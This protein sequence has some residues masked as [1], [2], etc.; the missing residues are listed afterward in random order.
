MKWIVSFAAAGLLLAATLA[1][2]A[3]VDVRWNV[4]VPMRDGVHLD[5]TVY[6]P[7][8]QKTPAPCIFTLT[9]YMADT[10]HERGMYFAAQGLPFLTIDD[11]GR[12]N[13]EGAFHHYRPDAR[14]GYDIVEWLAAQPYCNGKVG[15]WGGSYSGY[16]QWAVAKEAPPHLATIV[17]AAAVY[18]GL[19]FPFRGSIYYPFAMQWITMTSGRTA[20]T[21]VFGDRAFWTE[22]N[23]EWF[24]GGLPFSA[25]DAVV[26]NP[27]PVFQE[28][29]RH[30]HPDAYWDA[31]T[32]TTAQYGRIRHPVLTITG[33]YDA[34]QQG[35]LAYYRQHVSHA[36][37]EARDRH[38]LVIGPWDHQGTRTPSAEFGGL[39]LS[40][41]SLVDLPKLHVDWYRWT[42]Q[43]GPKPEF[44]RALVAYYVIGAERWRYA[45]SLQ[46]ITATRR[47]YFLQSDGSA[48]DVFASGTMSASGSARGQPDRY[49][50]DPRDI[51]SDRDS[52]PVWDYLLDQRT[53]YQS[54]GKQLVYHTAPFDADTELSGFFKLDAWLSID[55]PDT[56][57]GVSVYEIAQDGSSM[58]LT[59]DQIRA[60]YRENER[61]PK[62]VRTTEPLLYTFDRFTFISRQIR[63]GSRLRLV[64]A[65][66][67]SMYSEKNYNSGKSVSSESVQDAR[68]VRVTLYHDEAHPSSLYVPI[69]Q[70]QSADEHAVSKR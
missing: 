53:I 41:A 19:D 62:L 20:R 60:R 24:E 21:S 28:W 46:A 40:E 1:V 36:T 37:P 9:P 6:A 25:L 2:S 47:P 13:S 29:L 45:S 54:A 16:N 18:P 58:L 56:D 11:R 26:G 66:I 23:R 48:S 69:A 12:G 5:A 63:K 17:P 22:K 64:I 15:M 55:Q 50:Y 30:P 61:A 27:S 70:A 68:T 34:D 33:S 67:N 44:L 51:G 35:A 49:L 42:M 52:S 38:Y 8:D 10:N 59:S 7:R 14:D 4:R 39:K 43:D 65:P 32:P 3:P 57:F 31:L